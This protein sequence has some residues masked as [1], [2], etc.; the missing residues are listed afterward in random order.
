YEILGR[1]MNESHESCRKLYECSC[2][3]LDELVDVCRQ[4][5][6]Y[7][8]RLTGAGWGGCAVSLIPKDKLED[9]LKSVKEKYY[10]KNEKLNSLFSCSA[11][12]TKPS[13]G[14]SVI[15]L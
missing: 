5:G 4:S 14:I 3:E 10:N 6:A 15:N 8:S 9:F 2:D 12:S 11:F 13:N 1:L 7:G